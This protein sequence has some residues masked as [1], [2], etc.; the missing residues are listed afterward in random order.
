MIKKN[1]WKECEEVL[2]INDPIISPG[3]CPRSRAAQFHARVKADQR[4]T[5]HRTKGGE[6]CSG[7]SLAA[8][9][10]NGSQ[11]VRHSL[12]CSR[13]GPTWPQHSRCAMTSRM[14]AGGW[15]WLKR[16]AE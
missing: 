8:T 16:S 3:V 7:L 15:F 2:L 1:T 13:H 5:P 11:A 6:Q 9:S 14:S 4:E 12:H 10:A